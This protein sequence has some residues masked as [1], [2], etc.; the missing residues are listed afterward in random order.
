M[1]GDPYDVHDDPAYYPGTQVL[2]NVFDVRDSAEFEALEIELVALRA[3]E[4]IPGGKFDAAHYRAIHRHLLQDVYSWAGEYRSIRTGK[5]GNW[6][7]YP[8]YI[9]RE[10]DLLFGRLDADAFKSGSASKRFIPA[11]ADFVAELN[12]IHPFREGNGRTQLVF[13]RLLGQRA[14]HLFRVESIEPDEFLA[15]MI[16]SFGSNLAPLIDEL[17]RMLA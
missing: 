3:E 10:M 9:D 5:G 15:A 6:F 13:L 8:E 16:D 14:G 1:T 12:A 7:C 11:A 4:G 17:E 2:Q